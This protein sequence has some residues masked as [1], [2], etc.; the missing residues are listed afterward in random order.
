MYGARV[1]VQDEKVAKNYDAHNTAKCRVSLTSFSF[2]LHSPFEI[3]DMPVYGYTCTN[4]TLR[5]S[6]CCWRIMAC[7]FELC[8]CIVDAQII[9]F[10][11]KSRLALNN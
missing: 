6:C 1:T 8:R 7:L 11:V 9:P 2:H 5:G 3:N 10:S 4:N